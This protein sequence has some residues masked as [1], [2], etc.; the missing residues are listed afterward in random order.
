MA[1][2]VVCD[3]C[4]NFVHRRWTVFPVNHVPPVRPQKVC[5]PCYQEYE[6]EQSKPCPSC[7][8]KNWEKYFES[9]TGYKSVLCGTCKSD[10]VD[11]DFPGE[12]DED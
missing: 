6:Q 12:D 2:R 8:S 4:G 10:V 11:M 7:G 9:D 1:D 3:W 5:Y